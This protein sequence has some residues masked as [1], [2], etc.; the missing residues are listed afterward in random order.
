MRKKLTELMIREI[1]QKNIQPIGKPVIIPMPKYKH[2]LTSIPQEII[3]NAPKNANA[4][5]V[6]NK[7]DMSIRMSVLGQDMRKYTKCVI[8]DDDITYNYYPVQYYRRIAKN[9]KRV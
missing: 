3:K 5:L 2:N 4:Y 1:P 6:G 9:D 7:G 8:E